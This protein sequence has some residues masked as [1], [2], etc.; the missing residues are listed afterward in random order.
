M[1]ARSVILSHIQYPFTIFGLPPK[2][3]VIS[4][5]AGMVAYLITIVLGVI[6]LSVIALGAVAGY[7]LLWSHRL[8][9]RDRHIESVFL[10]T[11]AFWRFSSRRW[12]LTGAKAGVA[13]S[14]IG[15]RS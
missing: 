9:R 3:M 1:K 10:A 2:L 11:T 6:P 8:G 15:G 14:D 5:F 12:L 4:V 7:G 13:R